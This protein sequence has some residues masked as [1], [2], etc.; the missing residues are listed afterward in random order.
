MKTHNLPCLVCGNSMECVEIEMSDIGTVITFD[1]EPNE[2]FSIETV[3]DVEFWDAWCDCGAIYNGD[4]IEARLKHEWRGFAVDSGSMD[5]IIDHKDDSLMRNWLRAVM[6]E[7]PPLREFI[8]ELLCEYIA[9]IT[10]T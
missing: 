1:D 7:Y 2:H 8:T 5:D 3:D 9:R 6:N 4:M 10:C